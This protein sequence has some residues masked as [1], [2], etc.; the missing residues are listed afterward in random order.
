[1][2]TYKVLQ[3]IEAEDKLIGPLSLRQ[4]IYAGISVI[5][6]FIAFKLAFVN[7]ILIAPFIPIIVLFGVLALPFGH[8][9]P[10]EVWLLAKIK[11]FIKPH[12]RIWNKDGTINLVTI[13]APKA[14]P[15]PLTKNFTQ[16]E[17]KSRL[18]ALANTIDSRGWAIKNV[19]INL[20]TQSTQAQTP[21]STDRLIDPTTLP[22]AVPQADVSASDDIM[23]T[24][25]NPTAQHFQEMINT[26][27]KENKT[28]VTASLATP[29]KPKPSSGK[30]S[31]PPDYWFLNDQSSG[32]K[33]PAGYTKFGDDKVIS[34]YADEPTTTAPT[35]TPDEKKLLEKIETSRRESDLAN[36]H[37]HTLSPLNSKRPKPVIKPPVTKVTPPT[38]PD[39]IKLALANKENWSVATIARQ[40]EQAKRKENPPDEVIISLH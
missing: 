25:S 1:M 8:D 18:Q 2:A 9:Q 12:R 15:R 23:D 28:K 13:T 10:S 11:F 31:G 36:S 16:N 37:L 14:A 21:E 26:S 30:P 17:A 24:N 34:P 39:I 7:I 32:A 29:P 22:Q 40:A 27:R 4:F 38:N 20:N 5:A 6:L 19:N 3:D 33:V 35:E